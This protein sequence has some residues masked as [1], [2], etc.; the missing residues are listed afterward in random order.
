MNEPKYQIAMPDSLPDG[1][2]IMSINALMLLTEQASAI[3][4]ISVQDRIPEKKLQRV[5]ATTGH[6]RV[7]IMTRRHSCWDDF[8][9][10]WM[11]LPETPNN[12]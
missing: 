9:T 10:H 1:L 6:G 4:W 12:G 5:L 11:P 3:G 8:V 7:E 2:C